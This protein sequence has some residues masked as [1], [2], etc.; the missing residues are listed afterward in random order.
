MKGVSQ[1]L[2]VLLASIG[3]PAEKF[4]DLASTFK[5]VYEEL[6][7]APIYKEYSPTI[8]FS[9]VAPKDV[10]LDESDMSTEATTSIFE[11]VSSKYSNEG[12][13][14]AVYLPGLDCAGV[15]GF[16][17]FEDLSSPFEL[18]RM[19][20]TTT[21]RTLFGALVNTVVKFIEDVSDGGK[22][23]VTLI[24]E[25][26]G[27]QLAPVVAL[28]LQARK[29]NLK[30][31]V[32]VNPATSFDD[33][34]WDQLGPVLAAIG[35]FQPKVDDV[36]PYTVLG[37]LALSS[38]IP[39]SKQFQGIVEA[40]LN[41][42]VTSTDSGSD[43]VAAMQKGFGTLGK[44]LPPQLVAH[45]VREWLMVGSQLLT[46][47][48]LASLKMPVFVVAGVEDKFL[49]SKGEADR[50]TKLLPNSKKLLVKESGHFVLDN[51]VNLTEAIVYSNIDPLYLKESAAGY[52]DILDWKL[53]EEA[54]LRKTI[55]TRVK[56]LRRFTSPVFM[57]TS[58]K[59][60]RSLG[61]GKVPS[62]GP[63]VFVS[64]H[65]I[66]G[67]DLG[68]VIAQLIEDRGIVA[69]GLAHPVVFNSSRLPGEPDSPGIVNKVEATGPI[70]PAIFS[71]F[72]AVKVSPRNYYRLLQTG[73][74]ALLFPGGVREV[75]HGKDEAYKL[76]WPETPDFVRTAVR[77]NATIIPIAAVGSAD[78]V[79]IL[80]DAPDLVKLPFGIGEGIL[81][82]S[83]NTTSARFNKANTD[84]LFVPPLIVPKLPPARHYF[85]FGKPF[86][87]SNMNHKNSEDC[88]TLYQEVKS[89]LERGFDDVLRAR[90]QDPFKDGIQRLAYEQ[91][92]G[93]S[94]PTF[95]IDEMNRK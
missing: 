57:S 66:L 28:R 69:R 56:P 70:D 30:G 85:V 93:K 88:Q 91:L 1:V 89:E 12:K 3:Q 17:Q 53:P 55:D 26:F 31:L 48:R 51:R 25:S 39:D 90:E 47:E 68:M 27:G 74:N 23:D 61:L 49:P 54:E 21:D 80:V 78:S 84:E 50:L 65:Q 60:K 42:P 95:S 33:T 37:G 35:R 11:T 8:K 64:N 44:R 87:T 62:N 43:L 73:Q 15:S 29:I 67:L 75:F 9:F 34:N 72:G 86:E 94:A 2:S 63:L 82:R 24:G 41:V 20:V 77:F 59:G 32:M 22:R 19:S 13:P 52:D 76:F 92:N 16:Q 58:A 83:A 38:L 7:N 71:K 79:N 45:R 36:S 4:T 81:E 18:W 10:E 46:D 14:L 5:G 6:Q 40:I